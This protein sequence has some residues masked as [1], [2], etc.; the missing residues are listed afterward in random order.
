MIVVIHDF[1]EPD[2]P[3]L[4]RLDEGQFEVGPGDR[5]AEAGQ[6]R[7]A[8]DVGHMAALGNLAL[9]DSAVQDMP[10]P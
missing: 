1:L 2:H 3:P 7:T 5:Q 6:P 8:S 10:A 9:D 4:E